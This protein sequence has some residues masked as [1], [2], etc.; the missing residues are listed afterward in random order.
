M[1][2]GLDSWTKPFTEMESS[3]S[4]SAGKLLQDSVNFAR[5]HEAALITAGIVVAGTIAVVKT[6]SAGDLLSM[7]KPAAA[8]GADVLSKDATEALSQGTANVLSSDAVIPKAAPELANLAKLG[9]NADVLKGVNTFVFDLDRT[10]VPSGDAYAAHGEE[11]TN[12][13]VQHTGL[14]RDFVASAVDNTTR[15]LNSRLIEDRLDL[16]KPIQDLYPGVNLNEKFPDIA[17]AVKSAY[18]AALKPRPEV[19]DLLDTL[20]SQGKQLHVF[21]G[22]GPT[23]TAEKLDAS[24]LSKYFDQVFT[25][26]KDPIEDSRAVLTDA[27]TRS[28]IVELT[29]YPKVGDAGYRQI[30]NHLNVE[31]QTVLMTGDTNA[32]DIAPAQQVGMRTAQA[33]WIHHDTTTVAIPDLTLETPADLQHL[34]ATTID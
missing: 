11:L 31:P 5:D 13:L 22:S 19:V 4:D 33:N 12:Q 15:Q 20:K 17:P 10:L 23:T 27:T 14:S 34:F 29:T 1:A 8:S 24:G 21:T 18:T 28:K 7:L 3:L 25:G 16:I 2:E 9:E 6:G 30:I 32:L 26:G